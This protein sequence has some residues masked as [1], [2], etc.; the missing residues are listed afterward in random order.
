MLSQAF[1]LPY[2]N[3]YI[4]SQQSRASRLVDF[5]VN[6]G[7]VVTKRLSGS[8]NLTTLLCHIKP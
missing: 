4:P 5:T 7:L 8:T 3:A 2:Q 6:I 1:L